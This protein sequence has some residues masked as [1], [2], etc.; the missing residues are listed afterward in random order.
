[1][2]LHGLNGV[3]GSRKSKAPRANYCWAHL[4][5]IKGNRPAC[6]ERRRDGTEAHDPV[7]TRRR[8]QISPK[9]LGADLHGEQLRG[10]PG[11][12]NGLRCFLSGESPHEQCQL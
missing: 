3:G 7:T 11:I 10:A 9:I 8:E 12:L 5:G 6:A 2:W 4:L 1:M